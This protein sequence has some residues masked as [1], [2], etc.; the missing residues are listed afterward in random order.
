MIHFHENSNSHGERQQYEESLKSQ[1]WKNAKFYQIVNF[2][3]E[4]Q[5]TERVNSSTIM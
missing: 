5:T 3:F 1:F 2:H 4:N